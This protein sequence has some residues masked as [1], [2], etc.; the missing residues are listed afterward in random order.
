VFQ[1]AGHHLAGLPLQHGNLL[2]ARMQITSDNR[3]VRLLSRPALVLDSL[4]L[5]DLRSRRHPGMKG[6][7]ARA[8]PA[9]SSV[10]G[11]SVL[12]LSGSC[13]DQ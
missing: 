3:Q 11:L 13:W 6:S 10:E 2:V 8:S 9:L 1:P 12:R 7:L 4:S 5:P